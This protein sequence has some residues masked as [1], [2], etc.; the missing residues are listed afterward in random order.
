MKI[1]IIFSFFLL[2][3]VFATIIFGE[4]FLIPYKKELSRELFLMGFSAIP[5]SLVDD[6]LINSMGFT[7]DSIDIMKMRGTIRILTLGG[8]VMFNRR[9][10]ERLKNRFNTITIQH[11]EILGAA[12]RTHTTMSSVLKYKLLSKYNFDFVLIYHG[13][14]DLWANHTALEDF[15]DGYSHLN[16]WYKRNFLLDHSLIC[17]IIYN[18]FIYR[19][20]ATVLQAA[21]VDLPGERTFERNLI[22]LIKAISKNGSIPI[23]MTFAWNIPGNYTIESFKSNTLGYNNPTNYDK[24]PVELWGSPEYVREGLQRHNRIVRQI[25]NINNVLLIDQEKPLGESL[26]WFGDVCHLSEEGTEKFIN[27]ISNFFIEHGLF[28][29]T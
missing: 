2:L 5:N 20:P 25:A 21:F 19:K 13:I 15:K 12:L 27:N 16:P 29:K 3:T 8:S 17:R 11:I 9:M 7:G 22:T 26:Y 1:K 24:W 6:T 18:R 23:L 14:N 28:H 4:F 10:T